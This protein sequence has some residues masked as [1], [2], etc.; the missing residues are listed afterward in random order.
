[1]LFSMMKFVLRKIF[2]V[3]YIYWTFYY[4]VKFY[5]S[6]QLNYFGS[7]ILICVKLDG[8]RLFFSYYQCVYWFLIVPLQTN[9][10]F[11]RCVRL[12]VQYQNEVNPV[13]DLRLY[14]LLNRFVSIQ[15]R[16]QGYFYRHSG[17]KLYLQI[18]YYFYQDQTL[19]LKQ[20]L[21]FKG[22]F[23]P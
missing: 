8:C 12:A 4:C 22:I 20:W 7:V 15:P 10:L 19:F 11:F 9:G 21:A 6:L 2:E 17:K 14:A 23:R 3:F 5:S 16:M 13:S 1:M 18:T